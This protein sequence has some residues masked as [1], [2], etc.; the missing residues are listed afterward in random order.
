M[1]SLSLKLTLAFLF[2]GIISII[3]VSLFIRQR[4]QDE[5]DRFVLDRFQTDLLDS[6]AEYYEQNES[7]DGINTILVHNRGNRSGVPGYVAA[8]VTLLNIDRIV[9]YGGL[10]HQMGKQISPRD[11]KS[12]IPIHVHDDVVGWLLFDNLPNRGNRPLSDAPEATF[13]ENV[14]QAVLWGVAGAIGIAFILGIVL[15]RTI[16]RPVQELTEATRAVAQGEL[17]CQVPVRTQDELG[18]LAASFNQMSADLAHANQQRRQMTADI[19]HDLRSPLSVIMGYTEALDDD[20]LDGSP[21][22][23]HI[24]HKQAL[25]LNHLIDDLRTL[26]LADAGKLPLTRQ[27]IPTRELLERAALTHTAQAER[28]NIALRV[29]AASDLPLLDVDPDRMAQVLNNLVANAL[30]YTPD[31]GE[32]VFTAVS[33]LNNIHLQIKDNGSG[34]DPT[35][36]P[37]I[38]SRFYRGDKARAEGG[39][40]GLGL[41]IAKSLVEAQGGTITAESLPNQG[42]TFTIALPVAR[43][44]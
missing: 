11:S 12:A 23:Y 2:I 26:S 3:L 30:R 42:T 7:W 8:Q 40:S 29:D 19:A 22:I 24:M 1:R 28:K 34:I 31:G 14:N 16:S 44:R 6:L 4:T 13:L 17:G 41:A 18:N 25:L 39:E 36:L 15:A 33:H 38:F 27:P 5:F 43:K 9:V 20:K 21:E 35:D 10:R 32:I 37:H